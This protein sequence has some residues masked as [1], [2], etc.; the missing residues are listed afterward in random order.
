MNEKIDY[1]EEYKSKVYCV[2]CGGF[3][4]NIK[5]QKIKE[6]SK[7][8]NEQEMFRLLRKNILNYV[9]QHKNQ[10]YVSDIAIHFDVQPRKVIKIINELI[11]EKLLVEYK[12]LNKDN[13]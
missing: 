4:S 1:F 7:K 3:D 2:M 12:G 11:N 8:F 6:L 5:S 10:V 13:F 9:E